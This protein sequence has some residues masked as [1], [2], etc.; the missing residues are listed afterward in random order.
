[1]PTKKIINKKALKIV[2]E[3]KQLCGLLFGN[4]LQDIYL[5]G[6]YARGDYDEESDVDIML[7]LALTDNQI[8]AYRK[9]VSHIGSRLSLKYDI[10]VSII[11]VPLKRFIKYADDLPFYRNVINE[12]INYGLN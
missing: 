1:M 8:I 12:G 2:N 9:S 3:I 5:F 11:M 7:T 4:K 6:S 10:T